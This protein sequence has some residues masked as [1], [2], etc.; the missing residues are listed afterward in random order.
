M[1]TKEAKEILTTYKRWLLN[2][3]NVKPYGYEIK[4]ALDIAIQ[5]L[6]DNQ[7]ISINDKTPKDYKMVLYFDTRDKKINIGYF[8]WSQ[9]PVEYVSHWMPLPSTDS[10]NLE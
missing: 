6:E 9:T 4:E 2:E 1:T 5:C 7:W 10:I 8:V 3:E